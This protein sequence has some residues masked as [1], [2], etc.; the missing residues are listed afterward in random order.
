MVCKKYC[1]PRQSN[2]SDPS[3]HRGHSISMPLLNGH[4]VGYVIF[5][6][7]E[8]ES[9]AFLRTTKKQKS[10]WN[11]WFQGLS[12]VWRRD[13]DFS[14]RTFQPFKPIGSDTFWRFATNS[15]YKFSK[16]KIA[17]RHKNLPWKCRKSSINGALPPDNWYARRALQ[18]FR[19]KN[20]RR[21]AKKAEKEATFHRIQHTATQ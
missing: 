18:P 3:K 7:A 19:H 8:G 21:K 16:N 20:R 13:R 12:F 11:H 10:P 17:L 1:T 14:N 2:R 9:A 6:T 4:A 15:C 5:G